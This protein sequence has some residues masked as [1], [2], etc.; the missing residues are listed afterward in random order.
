[1]HDR[2]RSCQSSQITFAA[3]KLFHQAGE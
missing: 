3:G 1:M 2:P